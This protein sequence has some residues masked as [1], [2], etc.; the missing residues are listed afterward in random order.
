MYAD[1]YLILGDAVPVKKQEFKTD[2][3][4]IF[5]SGRQVEHE[6]LVEDRIHSSLLDVCLLLSHS[7]PVEQQIY[8]YIRVCET[9][10]KMK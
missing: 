3:S 6:R 7:L 8:F 4:Q 1:A 2:I 5:S 9:V 10:G